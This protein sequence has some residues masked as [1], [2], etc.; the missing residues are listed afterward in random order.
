MGQVV[1]LGN[2]RRAETW[3]FGPSLRK[4]NL[5]VWKRT[6]IK[7]DRRR[8]WNTSERSKTSKVH[9]VHWEGLRRASWWNSASCR[10]FELSGSG[11]SAEGP[12]PV[13][14]E[15][16]EKLLCAQ[17]ALGVRSLHRETGPCTRK[18]PSLGSAHS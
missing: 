13:S 17:L 7:V 3:N 8:V 1:S 6:S 4:W 10:I 15:R 16:A 12:V 14:L 11:P 2:L 18:L 9:K 5:D